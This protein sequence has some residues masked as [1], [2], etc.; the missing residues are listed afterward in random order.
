LSLE[1]YRNDELAISTLIRFLSEEAKAHK[2]STKLK[3]FIDPLHRRYLKWGFS[4]ATKA[5][6]LELFAHCLNHSLLKDDDMM[7]VF[8]D[9]CHFSIDMIPKSYLTI[10]FKMN[11]VSNRLPSFFAY[12][13]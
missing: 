11:P 13:F 1:I 12:L 2:K 6:A 8:R 10:A 7:K 3:E 9:P 5:K 4:T